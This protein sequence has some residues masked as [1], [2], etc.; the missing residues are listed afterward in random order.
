MWRSPICPHCSPPLVTNTTNTMAPA[1]AEMW[2][3]N[4]RQVGT[5]NSKTL[6]SL[7]SPAGVS[8][9]RPPLSSGVT[10][11]AR[12]V[13]LAAVIDRFIKEVCWQAG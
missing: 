10:A 8:R 6:S 4:F 11:F 3:S 1:V 12:V 5:G 13:Q 2:M 9:V 7:I